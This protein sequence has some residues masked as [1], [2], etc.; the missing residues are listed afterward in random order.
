MENMFNDCEQ[1]DK[2]VKAQ[3]KMDMFVND[4]TQLTK[5][6]GQLNLEEK[7]DMKVME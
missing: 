1:N 6:F 4:T 3:E 2:N 7:T 5:G